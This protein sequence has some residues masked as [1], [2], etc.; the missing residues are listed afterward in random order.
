[1]STIHPRPSTSSAD[2]DTDSDNASLNGDEDDSRRAL[3][4]D[5]N[6]EAVGNGALEKKRMSNAAFIKEMLVETFPTLAFST[7]GLVFTGELVETVA[8]WEVMKK[9]DELFILIPVLNNMK[10]NL[11]MN[12]SA[13]LSTSANMGELDSGP[14]RRGLLAGNI[15][16]LQL[17]ALIVSALASCLSFALATALKPPHDEKKKKHTGRLYRRKHVKKPKLHPGHEAPV[18]REFVMVLATSMSAAGLS[19]LTLGSF[20]CTLIVVCRAF[21]LN[22]DNIAPPIASALGDLLTLCILGLVGT[23][24][25]PKI[26]TIFPTLL[27]TFLLC[28]AGGAFFLTRKNT[29]VQHLIGLGWTPLFLAMIISTGSGL[30]LDSFVDKYE[31]YGLL[32]IVIGGLPGAVGS[33]FVSRISTYLHSSSEGGPDDDDE[34]PRLFLAASVLFSVTIP[35][36]ILF[37]SFLHFSGWLELHPTFVVVFLVFFCTAVIASLTIANFLTHVLWARG[38]DPDMYALPIQS[39]LVD[40]IGQCLLVASFEVARALG[41]K[42]VAHGS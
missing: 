12:L 40:L 35:I 28:G 7:V 32:A 39:S 9:I 17:Q 21:R 13:R 29:F 31:G 36:Q 2:A 20:M 23:A 38:L 10:G 19:A 8:E 24:L 1:M 34:D 3:L 30:A 22:P 41:G 18:W 37:L 6:V 11:E 14:V 16:L 15:S 27:A 4:Q 26:L 42:V 33:V 25:L 5:G